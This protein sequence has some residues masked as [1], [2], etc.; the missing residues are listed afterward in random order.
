MHRC[1]ITV[2]PWQL[3][4]LQELRRVSERSSVFQD[5]P[6]CELEQVQTIE[7]VRVSLQYH[8]HTLVECNMGNYFG[9][10]LRKLKATKR[11]TSMLPNVNHDF[12]LIELELVQ[13]NF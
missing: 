12:C 9:R 8:L 3:E 10:D 5:G 1:T 2:V 7:R 6:S 4:N 13:E 11:G